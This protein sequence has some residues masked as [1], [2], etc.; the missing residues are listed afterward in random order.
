MKNSKNI[1]PVIG[2]SPGNSYFKYDVIKKLLQKVVE[3]YGKVIIFVADVPAIF[4]YLAMG[5][6][7]NVARRDKAIPKGNNLKNKFRKA[8]EENGYSTEQ[9]KIINWKD[10]I[11][12]NS[13]YK[14]EYNKIISLY[15]NNPVFQEEADSTTRLVLSNIIK[16]ESKLKEAIKI[17]VNYLLSELAF[18]EFICKYLGIN[19]AIYIYHKH[20]KVYEDYIAGKFDDNPKVHLG[21][22]IIDVD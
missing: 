10:D 19:K 6:S 14:E 13:K 4:T 7:E 22:E 18:M 5:Y 3:K 11:E 20:W 12:G 2:V 16:S 21:F 8:A 9:V 15:K 17:A 1:Y